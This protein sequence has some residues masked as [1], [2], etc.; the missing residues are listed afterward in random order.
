MMF[1]SLAAI[2]GWHSL[3]FYMYIQLLLLAVE[4]ASVL[5]PRHQHLLSLVLGTLPYLGVYCIMYNG[6]MYAGINKIYT[7]AFKE[8]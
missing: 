1:S 8:Y 4:A 2:E 7:S 5:P 3:I 6:V